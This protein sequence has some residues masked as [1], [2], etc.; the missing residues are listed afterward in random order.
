[1]LSGHYMRANQRAFP[2]TIIDVSLGGIALVGPE[3]GAIGESVIVHID[4]LGQVQGDIVRY[5]EGGFAIKLTITT[6]ATQRLARRIT[7]LEANSTLR[8]LPEPRG[9]PLFELDDET[10]TPFRSPEEVEC[11]TIDLSLT[12]AD[13]VISPRSGRC[14]CSAWR[15]AR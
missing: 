14:S 9:L 10:L 3:R 1:L 6:R 5:L 12:G 2:C 11:E 13:V 8:R 4:Q 7:E 15:V